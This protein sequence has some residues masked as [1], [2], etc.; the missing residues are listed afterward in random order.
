MTSRRIGI[1]IALVTITIIGSSVCEVMARTWY[2]ASDGSG[3]APSIEAAMDSSVSGDT[4]LV[5]PGVYEIGSAIVL[6]EGVILLS[7]M[8]PSKTKLIPKPLY[9][10]RHAFICTFTTQHTEISGFWVEG[11][12]FYPPDSG[13]IAIWSCFHL[14]IR[15]NVMINNGTTAIEIDITL[16]A[17]VGIE[18]NTLINGGQADLIRGNAAGSFRNNIVWGRTQYLGRWWVQCNCMLDVSD[19]GSAAGLNF[20]A[21]PQYC[22]T[23]GTNLFLQSDSPCAPGNTPPPLS[24]CGLV[25]ALP[26]GCG[27]TPVR[28]K[29]WGEVK[30]LYR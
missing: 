1:W 27:S 7:E 8:G 14:Y 17:E 28:G 24:D 12:R 9:Y 22:G 6:T 20:Q 10:P 18:G 25:G 30:S 19:A 3:D 11:F 21:D 15:N 16:P 5:G 26:V 2:I 13:A 4:V 23:D 29:T